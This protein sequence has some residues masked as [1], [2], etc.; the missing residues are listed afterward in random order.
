MK[1]KYRNPLNAGELNDKQEELLKLIVAKDDIGESFWYGYTAVLLITMIQ[2]Y[3]NTLD[4][5]KSVDQMQQE[6]QIF[7]QK[8]KQELQKKDKE[9]KVDYKSTQ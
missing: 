3:I 7:L 2:Y 5:N 1:S 9:V 4:C 6:Y 8:E